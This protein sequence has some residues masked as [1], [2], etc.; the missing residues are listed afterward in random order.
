MKQE[1]EKFEVLD[2]FGHK[3][4]KVLTR[5]ANLEEDSYMGIV[6]IIVVNKE[7][8]ILVTKRHPNKT[9]GLMWEVT[10]GG[11]KAYETPLEAAIRELR[12]ET[13]IFSESLKFIQLRS[14]INDIFYC[15]QYIVFL[16]KDYTL[17]LGIDEVIDYKFLKPNDFFKFITTSQ[18]IS[19]IGE[20]ILDV[21]DEIMVLIKEE[22]RA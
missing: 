8:E 15:Y 4:G 18:F 10:G 16:D 5:G 9:P 13:G 2:R 7:G 19:Y 22:G 12:E 6:T 20:R 14:L 21:K 1:I 3:T 11:I 17:K